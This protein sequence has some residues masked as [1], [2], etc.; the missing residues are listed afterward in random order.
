VTEKGSR[1]L[2]LLDEQL[3]FDWTVAPLSEGNGETLCPF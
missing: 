1:E 3:H 2:P